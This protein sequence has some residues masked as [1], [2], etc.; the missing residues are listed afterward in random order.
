MSSGKKTQG[1]QKIEMKKMSNESNLQVTF[2]KRR[3]G[4]FKKASELCTLCGAYI[5]LII[6]SPSEKVFSFGYPNVETVIDRFLSQ[7]P[8]QNDDIMQ[9]LEDYRRA[10][11]RELNDLLTRMN[12]AIGIDK[13]RENE[14]I[15]VRMIN[16]TQFWW[17][18]PICEMNKVQLELYKKAL[19]DLLKLVAQH[20]D[21]VEMQGTSTQNI[22]FY[23]G[24][25]S[26]SRMP[27][28]HQPNP[29]QDS[30]FSAGFFQNPMLQPHLFGFNNMGE[31]CGHGPY[32]FF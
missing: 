19:E 6:F 31:E 9:L 20:A 1:R 23:V 16:E 30:T 25:G 18:R 29:Q 22:P 15:Q 14:L 10:N 7:V 32:G 3:I 21:R 2:S 26:S 27:L 5:A 4:L 13:N 12:D 17:T 8:P 28:E 11:V 24:N